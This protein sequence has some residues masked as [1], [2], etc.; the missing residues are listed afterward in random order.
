[1]DKLTS[2]DVSNVLLAEMVTL[3][4]EPTYKSPYQ[5]LINSWA[6]LPSLLASDLVSMLVG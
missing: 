3:L 1:M 4:I 6:L 2:V 5:K